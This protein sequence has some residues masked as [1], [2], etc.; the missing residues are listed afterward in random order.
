MFETDI[1][2]SHRDRDNRGR[3]RG[4]GRRRA[5]TALLVRVNAGCASGERLGRRRVCQTRTGCGMRGPWTLQTCTRV[6]VGGHS[7]QY[8]GQGMLPW[9]GPDRKDWLHSAGI[10]EGVVAEMGER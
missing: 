8:E 10:I 1:R 3:S 5:S 4:R 6:G 9:R 7:S 2:W